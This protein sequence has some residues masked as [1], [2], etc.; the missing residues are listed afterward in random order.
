MTE[1][2]K[3]VIHIPQK[4]NDCYESSMLYNNNIIKIK[5]LF[6]VLSLNGS[7]LTCE[8]YKG[9]NRIYDF[10][11]NLEKYLVNLISNNSNEWFG[12]NVSIDTA[13]KLLVSIILSSNNLEGMPCI[14]FN[15][16]N[17]DVFKKYIDTNILSG[18]IIDA[19]L[20]LTKIIFKEN[21]IATAIDCCKCDILDNMI[22]NSE[23]KFVF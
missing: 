1:I 6:K 11:V 15:I 4:N 19:E 7:V 16:K 21:Y 9:E 13:K 14:E 8:F 17:N 18:K 20:T 2:K 10:F 5:G 22:N 23:S 3:I 12:N